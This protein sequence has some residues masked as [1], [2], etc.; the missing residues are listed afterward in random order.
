MLLHERFVLAI[1]L[2][3]AIF[4]CNAPPSNVRDR[5]VPKNSPPLNPAPKEPYLSLPDKVVDE[6][7][8]F[9]SGDLPPR[10][11]LL[12]LSRWGSTLFAF[13]DV[14]RKKNDPASHQT[15]GRLIGIAVGGQGGL[16]GARGI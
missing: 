5:A 4:A 10:G 16:S 11:L 2:L 12:A 14:S 1:L 7:G 6:G 15:D 3:L 8:L 9:Y 13:L